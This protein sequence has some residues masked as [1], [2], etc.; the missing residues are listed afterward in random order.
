MLQPPHQ[1]LLSASTGAWLHW[2]A[3]GA[4]ATTAVAEAA[5]DKRQQQQHSFHV[6]GSIEFTVPPLL[7]AQRALVKLTPCYQAGRI[8]IQGEDVCTT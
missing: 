8:H 3:A 1:P 6:T 2:S 7:L 4:A 5:A